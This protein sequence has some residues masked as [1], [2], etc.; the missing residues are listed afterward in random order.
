MVL[1]TEQ[2]LQNL[3]VAKELLEFHQEMDTLPGGA[4][5]HLQSTKRY[6]DGAEL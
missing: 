2:F 4:R 1:N 6:S 3:G 5:R